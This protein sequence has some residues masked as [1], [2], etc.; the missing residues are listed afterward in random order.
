MKEVAIGQLF[1]GKTGLKL[2]GTFNLFGIMSDRVVHSPVAR[3]IMHLN[4]PLTLDVE[5]Y[6]VFTYSSKTFQSW[7]FLFLLSIILLGINSHI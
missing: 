6:P 1:R 5:L 3:C 4:V 2:Y 7:I